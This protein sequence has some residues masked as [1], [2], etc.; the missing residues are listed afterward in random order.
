MNRLIDFYRT[1]HNLVSSDSVEIKD[2]KVFVNGLSTRS[3]L[4]RISY[5]G[6]P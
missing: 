2:E 1:K 3:I 5:A 6:I 4:E